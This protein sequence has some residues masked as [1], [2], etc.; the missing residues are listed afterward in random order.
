MEFLLQVPVIIKIIATLIIILI[1]NKYLKELSYA[2]ILGTIILAA[3]SG[4]TLVSSFEIIKSKSSSLNTLFLLLTTLQVTWLSL[5]MSRT[6]MLK[7]MVIRLNT[8]VSPRSS[9]AILPAM[10]GL[11]PMPGGAIFSAPLVDE[12]DQDNKLYPLLKTK[13]NYW[14]RHVWEYWWPL[15]PGVL[16]AVDISGIGIAEFMLLQLPLSCFSILAG[17][18]FLLRKVK[19]F[20]KQDHSFNK[21]NL[22]LFLFTLTPVMVIVFT[23]IF[24]RIF[25]PAVAEYNKYLPMIIGIFWA[26]IILQFMQP[27]SKSN[28]KSIICSSKIYKLA[29]LVLL[30]LIYGA[31]VQAKLP[32]GTNL[33]YH[34]KG[35]L[36]NWGIPV[37]LV[38][39]LLPFISGLV[40][41]FAVGF[42][43]ASFP[44]IMSLIANSNSHS[45]L[46]A[47]VLL[48][49]GSGYVGMILSPVHIC[50]IVSN[51]HFKTNITKSISKLIKPEL[52]VFICTIILY[53]IIIKLF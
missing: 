53:Y 30:V 7:E 46:L 17:Y 31:F 9:M 39:I 21:N 10:I 32:D 48:A 18:L 28:F 44:I 2:V 16:L 37:L 8:L 47:T 19:L 13:I 38:V 50:L 29:L 33:M 6:G 15:Y 49:Y 27:I 1:A 4:H 45:E 41:G 51:E 23:Y 14:F 34:A 25:I 35:E 11:L 26:Q 43:G 24:I 52:F 36:A 22:Y 42:V 5:Q 40:T 20:K 3:W 12:C